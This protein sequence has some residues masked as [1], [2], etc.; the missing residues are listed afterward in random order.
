MLTLARQ[1]VRG[2]RRP[3]VATFV[4]L[5]MAVIV[6]VAAGVLVE[7]GRRGAVPPERYAGTPVV[8]AGD[9]RMPSPV[10]GGEAA[11]LPERV[12][13]PVSV[14]E[15]VSSVAGVRA[16]VL[17]QVVPM[18]VDIE[19]PDGQ[20][21][22]PVV[23]G[24]GWA[25]A[26]LWPMA[27]VEGGPPVGDDE[28]AIDAALAE[29]GQVG[30]GDE[31]RV[32]TIDGADGYRVAGVVAPSERSARRNLAVFVTDDVAL[33]LAG[34]PHL[35][36][37]LGVLVDEG[38]DPSAVA[39]EIATGL[40]PRFVALTGRSRADPE[41]L[42]LTARNHQLVELGGAFGGTALMLA[43]FVVAA[44]L[45]L[46]VLQRGREMA[47]LRAVGATPRQV[48]RMLVS[49]AGIIAVAATLTGVGPGLLLG[50][51]LF[52]VLRTEGVIAETTPLRL[53]LVPPAV[54][55]AA[56]LATAVLAA[57][58]AGRRA[59]RLHPTSALS[60]AAIEPRRVGW[61][62][63]GTGI[64]LVAGGLALSAL[65]STLEGEQGASAV[66]GVL[67]T[68]II[69]IA[70]LGPLLARGA[71]A[72]CGP[73]ATLGS[74][75]IGRLATIN[76]R[77]RARRLASA[78]T[79]LAL[80]VALTLTMVGSLATEASA[81]QDQAER[82]VTADRILSAPSGL[83]RHLPATIRATPGVTAAVEVK[84]TAIGVVRNELLGDALFEMRPAVGV[85][86]SGLDHVLDLD[87]RTGSLARLDQ[88]AVAVSTEVARSADVAVG[89]ELSVWL[90]DGT[91]HTLRVDATYARSLGF[92]DLVVPIE[93]IAGHTTDPSADQV[94]V[95]FDAD[96]AP[97][98]IDAALH[99]LTAALP[100]AA[101]VDR[102]E[103]GRDLA[104]VADQGA[105]VNY[106]FVGVLAVFVTAAVVNALVLA[107]GERTREL[108]LLRLLGATTRQVRT[109]IR[110]EAIV[111]ATYGTT[112]GL[113][114]AAATLVP[115]SIGIADTPVPSV[116]I[117]FV[118]LVVVA[119]FALTTAATEVP[120]R[121]AL[122]NDPA[123]IA[124]RAG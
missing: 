39:D 31:L 60:E 27:V 57:W 106:L 6:V 96:R 35:V 108:A 81:S 111:L 118:G 25:S 67:L 69:G 82:R 37:A 90:G 59:S 75:A 70:A 87:V 109:M 58:L 7:S 85:S 42:D 44:T 55:L 92:A 40:D 122:R 121:L 33:R 50:T 32:T 79:P 98:R 17:D 5:T 112:L 3:F 89:D 80:A 20:D 97:L 56:G 77:A 76:L 110:R 100:G 113:V 22:S 101:V 124:T 48:R 1:T 62:R 9:Q 29:A 88:G 53:S 16:V 45:G 103:L 13:V 34:D 14:A 28:I 52:D 12:R 38:V 51:A 83:P 2:R 71:G 105:S 21:G 119:S 11:R 115:F 4:V 102:T 54:A 84:T 104:R 24:Q 49:E 99:D 47:L 18:A 63:L 43:T 61:L 10:E 114:V 26:V 94:L 46:T 93:T 23:V 73:L 68:L 8:V 91:A 95:S 78:S 107:T 123:E 116:P 64:V 65:A 36:D 120:A 86:A 30:V 15:Q 41:S 19:P 66:V 117:G 72:I 74:P